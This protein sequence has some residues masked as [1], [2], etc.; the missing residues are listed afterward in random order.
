MSLSAVVVDDEIKARNFLSQLL[1]D[2]PEIDVKKKFA[3]ATEAYDFIVKH[4]PDILFLDIM[5]PD[6]D[7][8]HFANRLK[9]LSLPS[10][11]IFVTAYEEYAIEAIKAS[12]YAYFLK[13]VD[14]H[15]LYCA[16]HQV[17]GE[18]RT[19]ES[20]SN[21][22]PTKNNSPRK[23]RFNQR[24]GFVLIPEDDILFCRAE[25]NYTLIKRIDGRDEMV[26]LNL[27]VVFK[28]LSPA[29]FRRVSRSYAI[30]INFLYRI[31]SK[32]GYCELENHELYKIPT[33]KKML[34]ELLGQLSKEDFS[35]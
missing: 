3:S 21:I 23:I 10:K 19:K 14:K 13:P 30:N 15:E 32:G 7:G 24:A 18:K 34:Q 25:G 20:N 31:N 33:S 29:I 6:E 11:I 1:G 22:K 5:L 8:I 4:P 27:G 26:A 16:I 2:L 28:K 17:L 12:A 35:S 9:T